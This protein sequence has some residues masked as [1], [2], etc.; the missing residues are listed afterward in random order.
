MR[1]YRRGRMRVKLRGAR[2]PPAPWLRPGT[3]RFEASI[4]R[5]L[6]LFVASDGKITDFLLMDK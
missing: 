6:T 5:D 3:N 1:P 2:L 4:T